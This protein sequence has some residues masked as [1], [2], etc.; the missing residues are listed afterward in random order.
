MIE[1]NPC[2]VLFLGSVPSII[3]QTNLDMLKIKFLPVKMSNMCMHGE[4]STFD[5]VLI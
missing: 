4:N 3:S 5:I 2:N 1:P